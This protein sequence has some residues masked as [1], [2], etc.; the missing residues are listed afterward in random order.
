MSVEFRPAERTDLSLLILIAGGTG[1]GK[2]E[3]AMRL[4]AGL[5]GGKRFACIDTENGRALHKAD[6]YDFDHAS[7]TEPFTPERYIEAVKAADAAGYPVIVIDSGSHEYDG[8]GGLLDMQA[9]EFKRLGGTAAVSPLSWSEPKKRDRR[10]R[11]TLITASAHVILCLRAEDKI[12]IVRKDGKTVIQPLS[13]IPG[14]SINGWAPICEKR[15][16]FEATISLLLTADAPGIPKPIKLERR[17]EGL[18][19]LDRQLDESVGVALA[20]WARGKAAKP[21]ASETRKV[22]VEAGELEEELLA[23]GVQLGRTDVESAIERK[24]D[25]VG[26]VAWLEKQVANAR[27]AVAQQAGVVA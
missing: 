7:L 5:A 24:R 22:A 2:T 9:E 26:F 25:D 8:P 16:P 17:H 10:Y 11:Q 12:E 27:E 14:K 13:T 19:P 4:A 21:S 3:S 23:L 18:V 1:S 6:D 20:D 15:L